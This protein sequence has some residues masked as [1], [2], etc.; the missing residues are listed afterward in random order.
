MFNI[1]TLN[2]ISPVGLKHFCDNKYNVGDNVENPDAILLR[3]F[4]MHDMELPA[5]LL[6]IGRAG[7]GTNN[8]PVDKCAEKG[9]VVFNTPGANAN[10]VKELTILGL[11]LS[12][13]KVVKGYDWVQSLGG[14]EDVAKQVEK[15]KSAFVGPEVYGKKLAVIGL[16]A[17][18]I[19]VANTAYHLGMD[20][21]GYDP[22]ISVKAALGLSR[23]V[24]L[25]SDLKSLLE[26]ADYV[27][28]H[29]PL[30][31]DTKH[32][33]NEETIEYMKDGARLLNFARG[34]LV[35]NAAVKK[36]LESGKLS[37][38]VTDFPNEELL[39]VDNIV[40]I[41]HLG[42]STPESEENCAEMA[43]KEI[44]DYL[45]N[46]NI[47]NSVNFPHCELPREGVRITITHKNIPNMLSRF[48]TILADANVNIENMVNKGKKE[49]AYTI[50]DIADAPDNGITEKIKSIDGVISVRV[51]L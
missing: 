32:M 15:G 6:A 2:K 33:I 14:S 38:Y 17:I 47:V 30:T 10:A 45:E 5:G 36:A 4:S 37:A 20:V 34:D 40:T 43:A 48:S 18:G 16:G 7:A 11:L 27:S 1:K 3:S 8:I 41:P 49:Y 44:I 39:G 24:S 42:A 12:S 51:I 9:I 22:Y 50:I 28:I 25:N 21:L 31:P 26:D 13:R 19:M 35:D 23:H 46:G 29:V